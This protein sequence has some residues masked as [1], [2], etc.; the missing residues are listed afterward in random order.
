M[1]SLPSHR[2]GTEQEGFEPPVPF[3][4]VVFKTTALSR[5]ATA[6]GRGGHAHF[7]SPFYASTGILQVTTST[8]VIGDTA[9]TSDPHAAYNRCNSM[10]GK[11]LV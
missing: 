4:T 3:G 2:L 6:P 10:T 5:S 9:L 8:V 11:P 7:E 1:A